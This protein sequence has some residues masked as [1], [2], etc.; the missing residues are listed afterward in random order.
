MNKDASLEFRTCPT[1]LNPNR[2][3]LNRLRQYTINNQHE[4]GEFDILMKNCDLWKIS[5]VQNRKKRGKVV[6]AKYTQKPNH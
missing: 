6:S 1:Y 4:G 5:K 3:T 2:C